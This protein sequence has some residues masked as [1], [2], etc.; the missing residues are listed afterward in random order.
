[1]SAWGVPLVAHG[2]D[3]ESLARRREP[4]GRDPGEDAARFAEELVSLAISSGCTVAGV[5]TADVFSDTRAALHE[6]RARGLH[7]G[8]QFTYRNPD[9]STDPTR[10]VSG[11]RA[12]VVGAVDYRRADADEPGGD[13]APAPSR[14]R[15]AEYARHDYY[16]DLRSALTAVAE[17]LRREGWQAAVVCDDNALVDRAAAHRAG[18]GWFGRN[19]LLLLPG[20]GSRVVLGSVVT[21][22][23]LL[24]VSGD[25]EPAAHGAGCG[26]CHRCQEACPTGALDEAGVLDAR[27]CLAWLLQA[28]G[29]FPLEHRAALGDRIYGCDEC[30]AACPINRRADRSRPPAEAEPDRRSRVDVLRMLSLGD[31]ELLAEFGRWYV[32]HRDPR[33]LR[34]NAL[35]VLGNVGE[36]QDPAIVAALTRWMRQGDELLAEHA[37]WAARRLG[38][39]EQ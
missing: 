25:A 24:S 23:P 18:L 2:P 30:Q 7:G 4:P 15:V 33:Y 39:A 26:S 3:T 34:R 35:V 6:R 17:R 11:A 9:R 28:P 38:L 16:R 37:R 14:A 21:D 1:M 29:S 20:L 12:L 5:T 19:S 22:A 8:M 36:R 32:P 10:I 31:A 13:G 27:R